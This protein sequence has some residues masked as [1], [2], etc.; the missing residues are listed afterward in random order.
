[1]KE[2]EGSIEIDAQPDTVCHFMADSDK[3]RARSGETREFP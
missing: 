2:L 3:I 1:M